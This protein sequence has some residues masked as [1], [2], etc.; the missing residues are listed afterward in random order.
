MPLRPLLCCL[1]AALLALGGCQT[2][3]PMKASEPAPLEAA[4]AALRE[5][6]AWTDH[7]PLSFPRHPAGVYLKDWYIV[8]D[9]GHGGDAHIPG[10]K[11][12]PTGVREAEINWRVALLL[13]ELLEA[14]GARVFL[15][16]DG[17]F[18]VSNADRAAFA[19]T[20]PRADGGEGADLFLSLHHN[21]SSNPDSNYTS[22]WYH[23]EARWNESVLDLAVILGHSLGRHLRTEVGRTSL[24]M[25]DQQMYPQGFRVLRDARVPALLL[26][27]SFHSN[28]AE[29]QRLRDGFYNLRE[30]YAIYEALCE[31]AYAGRPTQSLVATEDHPEGFGMV[32]ELD[33]GLPKNWWGAERERI[34]P[35][36]L[37]IRLG[38]NI[39]PHRYDRDTRTVAAILPADTPDGAILSLHFTN[40]MKRHN[41]PQRHRIRMEA[42]PPVLEAIGTKR[43]FAPDPR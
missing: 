36:T 31:Y 43:P 28:P 18:D 24:L 15:T 13:Q 3:D 7:A 35:S 34:L 17:D 14:E 5:R 9:P 1:A 16:R 25:S 32:W 19:N 2:T 30:A 40:F 22:I 21:A 39:L 37:Q 6:P 23:G 27:S 20:L 4:L 8:L 33:D 11:R 42:T 41:H 10:Y 38:D 29:E 12:G 26:E